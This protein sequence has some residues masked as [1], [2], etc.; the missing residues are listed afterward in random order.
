MRG[1]RGESGEC[2]AARYGSRGLGGGQPERVTLSLGASCTN[3]ANHAA[4]PSCKILVVAMVALHREAAVMPASRRDS[5]SS[6]RVV[7]LTEAPSVVV[8]RRCSPWLDAQGAARTMIDRQPLSLETSSEFG[9]A[10]HVMPGFID[11][12]R[13]AIAQVPTNSSEP[14]KIG[15][16]ESLRTQLP[17]HVAMAQPSPKLPTTLRREVRDYSYHQPAIAA[18][19]CPRCL[20]QAVQG[21]PARRASELPSRSRESEDALRQCR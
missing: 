5:D 10:H 20:S 12:R 7:R 15:L 9:P 6:T 11:L 13:L 18:G 14:G 3:L 19:R 2:G 4:Y 21:T 17:Q 1:R 16:G 8:V